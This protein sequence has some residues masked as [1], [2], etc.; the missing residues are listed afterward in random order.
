[1]TE[2]SSSDF[3][4]L[5]TLYDPDGSGVLAVVTVREQSS[6]FRVYSF[7]FFKEFEKDGVTKRTAYLNDRHIGVAR[8]LL[9]KIEATI[10]KAQE[11]DKA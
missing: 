7:A 6:G 3:V 8:R 5:D 10:C 4:T 9:D 11:Q 1:M 2:K